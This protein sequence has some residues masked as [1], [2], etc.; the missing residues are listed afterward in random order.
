MTCYIHRNSPLRLLRVGRLFA[1][2]GTPNKTSANGSDN[3]LRSLLNEAV[4]GHKPMQVT[5]PVIQSFYPRLTQ[6]A[7]CDIPDEQLL[8]F[9]TGCA[10]FTLQLDFEFGLG[11]NLGW[12]RSRILDLSGKIVG[13]T[14]WWGK[15]QMMSNYY[16]TGKH[17][18]IQIGSRRVLDYVPQVIILQV[19]ER[20]GIY[21]R[22][23]TAKIEQAA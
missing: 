1:D 8:F 18:F 7:L 15:E 12:N 23:N 19:E 2:T 9:W 4:Q 3:T 10:T 6:E 21:Y 11:V 16:T 14:G 20:D 22:V 5:F 17:F 13:S